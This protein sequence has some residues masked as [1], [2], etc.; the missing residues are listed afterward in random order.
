MAATDA[1]VDRSETSLRNVCRLPVSQPLP[2]A[3]SFHVTHRHITSER[4]DPRRAGNPAFA[5]EEPPFL[6]E[7]RQSRLPDKDFESLQTKWANTWASERLPRQRSVHCASKRADARAALE[8]GHAKEPVPTLGPMFGDEASA[9][10]AQALAEAVRSLLAAGLGAQARPL[11]DELV[12]L[13]ESKRGPVAS[14]IQIRRLN[15]RS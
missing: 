11:V 3:L 1:V 2:Q 15:E 14:V 9:A 10:K 8:A 12:A 5:C 6:R 13:I 4:Q 7:R